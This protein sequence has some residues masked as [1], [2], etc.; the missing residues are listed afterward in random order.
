MA[1]TPTN[2]FKDEAPGASLRESVD[3]EKTKLLRLM[4]DHGSQAQ[5]IYD[6]AQRRTQ[7]SQAG[8]TQR[9]AGSTKNFQV[10]PALLREVERE[11]SAFLDIYNEALAGAA[12]EER[13]QQQRAQSIEAVYKDSVIADQELLAEQAQQDIEDFLDRARGRRGGGGRG[14]G[15]R[16]GPARPEATIPESYLRNRE[17]MEARANS[18]GNQWANLPW[19]REQQQAFDLRGWGRDALANVRDLTR[20]AGGPNQDLA[21]RQSGTPETSA[22]SWRVGR[23][24]EPEST[25]SVSSWRRG[26]AGSPSSTPST[27]SWRRAR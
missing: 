9:A 17:M 12:T 18:L 25:P 11:H 19:S 27:S 10:P 6:E 22:A 26:R 15:G 2:F 8:A 16:S 24:G 3:D 7:A 21:P 4:A 13:R 20:T 23:A 14:G 1:E 5:T